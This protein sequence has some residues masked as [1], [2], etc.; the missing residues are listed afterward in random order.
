LDDWFRIGAGIKKASQLYFSFGYEVRPGVELRN[1]IDP[2]M[3]KKVFK[4]RDIPAG[5]TRRQTL[6]HIVGAH[7]RNTPTR[8]EVTEIAAYLRGKRKFTVNGVEFTLYSPDLEQYSAYQDRVLNH[9]IALEQN[10]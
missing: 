8:D 4:G 1:Y 2:E 10:Q 9:Q 3:V 5:L 6:M 7:V